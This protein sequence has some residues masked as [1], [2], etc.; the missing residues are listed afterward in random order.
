MELTKDSIHALL[1]S[2]DQAVERALVA[3]YKRQTPME[4]A[5]AATLRQ[6]GEGF[7]ASDARVLTVRAERLL[8]GFTLNSK[9]IEDTRQRIKKYWQ[10]LIEVAAEKA[11]SNLIS[12]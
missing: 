9:E 6:N 4:K 8:N 7:T 10:Q 3:V 12:L 2:R 11:L 5:Q 1:D